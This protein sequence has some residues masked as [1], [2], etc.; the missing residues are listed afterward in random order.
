MSS[1]RA[2]SEQGGRH[3]I[4]WDQQGHLRCR[5]ILAASRDRIFKSMQG[6]LVTLNNESTRD[7]DE[8][9]AAALKGLWKA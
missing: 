6:A 8:L 5:Q 7:T 3:A 2:E 1:I 9:A 4:H